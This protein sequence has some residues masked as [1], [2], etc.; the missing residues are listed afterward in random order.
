MAPTDHAGGPGGRAGDSRAP[1][2]CRG[3]NRRDESESTVCA[4]PH[5]AARAALP[6]GARLIGPDS[7]A[8]SGGPVLKTTDGPEGATLDSGEGI[9]VVSHGSFLPCRRSRRLPFQLCP[10]VLQPVCHSGARRGPLESAGNR[11]MPTIW[12]DILPQSEIPEH[13]R[14]LTLPSF[15]APTARKRGTR[16]TRVQV[17]SAAPR[18]PSTASGPGPARVTAARGRSPTLGQ[19]GPVWRDPTAGPESPSGARRGPSSVTRKRTGPARKCRQ[20]TC[21]CDHTHTQP[22]VHPRATSG[23]PTGNPCATL[24]P[25]VCNYA[26]PRQPTRREPAGSPQVASK[27]AARWAQGVCKKRCNPPGGNGFFDGG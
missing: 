11:Q 2:G 12:A 23:P 1:R 17:A 27:V 9:G 25:P 13:R 3:R 14:V 24:G 22:R 26:G 6:A 8:P 20:P 18:R 5:D 7:V 19:S 15:Q 4:G 16:S 10:R 21:N